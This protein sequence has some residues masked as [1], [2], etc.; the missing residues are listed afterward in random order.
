MMMMMMK[1]LPGG[2]YCYVLS[3]PVAQSAQDGC[4]ALNGNRSGRK[5][6]CPNWRCG[7]I[8]MCPG[9]GYPDGGVRGFTFSFLG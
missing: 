9:T 3:V 8:P 4:C 5:H 2:V 1:K 7:P 6:S